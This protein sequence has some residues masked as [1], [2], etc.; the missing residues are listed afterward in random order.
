[1]TILIAGVVVVFVQR[2]LGLSAVQQQKLSCCCIPL[3]FFSMKF[4]EEEEEGKDLF[5]HHKCAHGRVRD[6]KPIGKYLEK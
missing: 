1:M 4:M 6:G 2:K 3:L 5:K